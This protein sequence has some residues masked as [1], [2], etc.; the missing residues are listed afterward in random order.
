MI[1]SGFGGFRLHRRARIVPILVVVI[2]HVIQIRVIVR[3]TERIPIK[4]PDKLSKKGRMVAV[5]ET[6]IL[7]QR[8]VTAN[9]GSHPECGAG[10]VA[11]EATMMTA[12]M[13]LTAGRGRLRRGG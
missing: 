5:K 8:E 9:S 4:R 6:A 13:E 2:R 11:N 10:T 1:A 7:I 12:S 3:I